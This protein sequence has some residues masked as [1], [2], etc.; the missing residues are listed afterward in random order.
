MKKNGRNG[1]VSRG[2]RSGGGTGLRSGEIGGESHC[3]PSLGRRYARARRAGSARDWPG[4]VAGGQ[5]SA[6]RRNA[7]SG[8]GGEKRASGPSRLRLGGATDC[9]E[10]ALNRSGNYNRGRGPV[11]R[12][13]AL[14]DAS[15]AGFAGTFRLL[16]SLWDS[17]GAGGRVP[18]ADAPWLT[19]DVPA[20]LRSRKADGLVR[21]TG[22][23]G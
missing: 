17:D 6:M 19:T 23:N 10:I 21:P 15:E 16:P 7:A 14:W 12:P 8:S 22:W 4:L 1:T 18:G 13:S 3:C 9:Q 2:V 20:G 5:Y 11:K